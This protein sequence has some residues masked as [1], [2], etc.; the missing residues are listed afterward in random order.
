MVKKKEKEK[1]N[2]KKFLIRDK[3][4]GLFDGESALI[5]SIR[6]YSWAKLINLAFSYLFIRRPWRSYCITIYI[7]GDFKKSLR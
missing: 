1:E 5:E 2:K 4:S 3:L 7:D 6:F